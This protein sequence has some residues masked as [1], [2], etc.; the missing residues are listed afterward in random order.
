MRILYVGTFSLVVTH[1][2]WT[3]KAGPHEMNLF[4]FSRRDEMLPEVPECFKILEYLL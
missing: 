2:P 4:L 3:Y 1:G